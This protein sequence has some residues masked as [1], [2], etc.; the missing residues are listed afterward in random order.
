MA[1]PVGCYLYYEVKITTPGLAQ[2]GFVNGSFRPSPSSGRGVGDDG[3]SWGYDGSRVYKWH[4]SGSRFGERWKEG[5]VIGVAVGCGRIGAGKGSIGSDG[6]WMF[7]GV[8]TSDLR[9]G[10]T[11]NKTAVV[12][13]NLGPDGFVHEKPRNYIPVGS[14]VDNDNDGNFK[15][16][17]GKVV[18]PGRKR[19][20]EIKVGGCKVQCW[21]IEGVGGRGFKEG[22]EEGWM[23]EGVEDVNPKVEV[24]PVAFKKVW[25]NSEIGIWW[26]VP[27]EGYQST[28]CVFKGGFTEPDIKCTRCSREEDVVDASEVARGR[29]DQGQVVWCEGGGIYF[30]GYGERR[31]FW[32]RKGKGGMG[33]RTERGV[34]EGRINRGW[35]EVLMRT[36]EGLTGKDVEGRILRRLVEGMEGKV[37]L[38]KGRSDELV[39]LSQAAKTA[40]ARTSVQDAI[41]LTHRSNPFRD[42][43][44]SSQD[45]ARLLKE[46]IRNGGEWKVEEGLRNR[47][48]EE[49]KIMMEQGNGTFLNSKLTSIV[50]VLVAAGEDDEE[51]KEVDE[52]WVIEE[53]RIGEVLRDVQNAVKGGEWNVRSQVRPSKERRTVYCYNTITNNLKLVASLLPARSSQRWMVRA[54]L[55]TFEFSEVVLHAGAD[56]KTTGEV[57][58]EEA[59]GVRVV[60]YPKMDLG[61]GAVVVK[62][63]RKRESSKKGEDGKVRFGEERSDEL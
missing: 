1:V 53:P 45:T 11:V 3:C 34:K 41:I 55:E 40:R 33:W 58:V 19:I 2:I 63:K 44:R 12:E 51:H 10:V 39:T 62:G 54:Y 18:Q 52:R 23:E 48:M 8:P 16:E 29:L 60:F 15:V 14:Y 26:P 21:M 57:K 49:I 36:T 42:S 47:I 31:K 24:H 9:V 35:G 25:G 28:G 61:G 7:R 6:F 4:R 13:V 56:E 5:D 50:D 32:R 17:R 20:G 59:I 37:R 22:K 27:P 38:D 43:L 30:V 46:R